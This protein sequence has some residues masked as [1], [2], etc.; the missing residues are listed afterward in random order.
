MVA[1]LRTRLTLAEE[2]LSELK[3][4]LRTCDV[5]AMLGANKRRR[6]CYRHLR[7]RCHGGGGCVRPDERDPCSRRQLLFDHKHR[8]VTACLES[9]TSR[10]IWPNRHQLNSRSRPS[11]ARTAPV[12]WACRINHHSP[13]DKSEPGPE[14]RTPEAC[15]QAS[16]C[17]DW[18][19]MTS[20]PLSSA[21]RCIDRRS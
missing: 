5:T 8:Q 16:K 20:I 3:R 1:E 9:Q 15:W 18:P 6:A 21:C 13:R 11:R 4:C 12:R 7:Q 17:G 19:R 14:G 2:R 10:V